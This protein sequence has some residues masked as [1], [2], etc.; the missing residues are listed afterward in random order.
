MSITNLLEQYGMIIEH[1]RH[2]IAECRDC[3][4]K[5]VDVLGELDFG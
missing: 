3:S 1:L 4:C 2:H 5:L